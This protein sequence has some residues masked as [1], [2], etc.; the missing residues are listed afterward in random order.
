MLRQWVQRTEMQHSHLSLMLL[1]RHVHHQAAAAFDTPS[2]R[3][4]TQLIA[5][6]LLGTAYKATTTVGLPNTLVQHA[7]GAD[8]LG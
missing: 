2:G 1:T 3:S 8:Q 7:E 4:A 5:D 6:N